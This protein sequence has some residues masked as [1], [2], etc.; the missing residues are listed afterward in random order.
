MPVPHYY[1]DIR[2][3]DEFV[4]DEKGVVSEDIAQAQMEAAASLADIS[5][6]FAM[7]SPQPLGYSLS[8]EVRD[9]NGPLFEVAFRFVRH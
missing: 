4:K 6:E 8:M 3:G 2:D 1:F 5:K 7:R 9:S